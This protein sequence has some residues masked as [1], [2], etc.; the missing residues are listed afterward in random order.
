M[1]LIHWRKR[2][3]SERI[4]D[5]FNL[6][7]QGL[8]VPL[9]S[10]LIGTILIPIFFQLNSKIQISPWLLFLL[11]FT[12]VDYLY[13]WNH[14]LLHTK[15]LWFL[16]FTHH[17]TE[18]LD[19]LAASRNS[20]WTSYFL[21]YVWFHGFVIY[22]FEN[23][24]FYVYGLW[25][26]GLLDLWRHSGTQTPRLFK[27]LGFIF[28]LPE[29]HE[30]HHS[31]DKNNINFGAN[32]NI[33]DRLHGTFFREAKFARAKNLGNYKREHWKVEFLYPWRIKEH[34]EPGFQA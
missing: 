21:V 20:I 5:S 12:L 31:Q 16:H 27:F 33:W 24:E 14:R 7:N 15:K 28:I 10:V 9:V 3:L 1:G 11:P 4:F 2:S 13:Y 29:D 8:I 26:H 22:F 34:H 18:N 6:M 30:W 23:T 25:L 32:L 17:S 19:I